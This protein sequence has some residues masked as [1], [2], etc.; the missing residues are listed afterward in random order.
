M[1]RLSRSSPAEW[2]W[3]QWWIV[4]A[5]LIG[6]TL[7]DAVTWLQR[8]YPDCGDPDPLRRPAAVVLLVMTLFALL[9]IV[10]GIVRLV[11]R[12]YSGYVW[13]LQPIAVVLA[14]LATVGNTLC[15]S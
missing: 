10:V 5:I 9:S 6:L 12:Y 14:W 4:P 3:S 11:R 15:S 2:R 8:G 7:A 1:P 13:L